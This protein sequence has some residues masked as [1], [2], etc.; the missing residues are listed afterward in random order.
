MEQGKSRVKTQQPFHWNTG[1]LVKNGIHRIDSDNRRH[2][3]GGLI[4]FPKYHPPK[5]SQ[6]CVNP[7]EKTI[8]TGGV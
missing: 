3:K 8:V 4:A 6:I 1:W 2:I 7:L 5:G